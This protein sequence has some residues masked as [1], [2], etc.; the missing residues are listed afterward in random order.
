MKGGEQ[1]MDEEKKRLFRIK[2]GFEKVE[3]PIS[4]SRKAVLKK[5]K[6]RGKKC[7]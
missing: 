5:A 3:E 1:V 6:R 7:A 2:F 4:I